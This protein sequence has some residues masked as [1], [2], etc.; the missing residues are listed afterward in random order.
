MVL[1]YARARSNTA[2]ARTLRT[3]RY[4]CRHAVFVLAYMLMHGVVACYAMHVTHVLPVMPRHRVTLFVCQSVRR[5]LHFKSER[6][7]PDRTSAT[8]KAPPKPLHSGS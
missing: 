8:F 5:S 3:R 7:S 1:Q 2:D 4:A 6:I